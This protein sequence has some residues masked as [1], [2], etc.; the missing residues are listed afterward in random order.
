MNPSSVSRGI[1]KSHSEYTKES[2]SRECLEMLVTEEIMRTK[3]NQQQTLIHNIFCN[4][5]R[6]VNILTNLNVVDQSKT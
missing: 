1:H 6:F 5:N 2:E 4:K 3:F